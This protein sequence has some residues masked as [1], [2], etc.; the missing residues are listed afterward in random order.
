MTEE[1][2]SHFWA[3]PVTD[4]TRPTSTVHFDDACPA[5]A[6]QD[7]PVA[8]PAIPTLDSTVHV[9]PVVGES[10]AGLR[11]NLVELSASGHGSSRTLRDM[12]D[13]IGRVRLDV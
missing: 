10:L 4:P 5:A 11:Q 1:G 12:F 8:D 7:T 2:I 13:P 3:N 6:Q 9:M